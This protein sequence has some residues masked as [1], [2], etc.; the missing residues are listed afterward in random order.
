MNS[1]N[2]NHIPVLLHEA[3]EALAIKPD[4]YYVD[5]TLGACGHTREI[6]KRLS[7]KGR[8]LGFDCD[9]VA[10]DYAQKLNDKRLIVCHQKFSALGEELT[11]V[12]WDKVAGILVDLGVSS[13]QLDKADRGFSFLKPA[14]LDMRMDV[15][16]E[17]TAERWINSIDEL[18]LKEAIKYEGEERNASKI[19]KA[20]VKIRDNEHINTTTGL[21]EIIRKCVSGNENWR[22][23]ATRTFQAIRI[24]INAEHTQLSAILPQVAQ[25]LKPN[26][27]FVAIAFHSLEDRTIKNFINADALNLQK[28]IDALPKGL[29]VINQNLVFP[30]NY[31]RQ[32]GKATRA[33]AKE[34]SDNPRSHSAIM[35]VAEKIID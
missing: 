14:F 20:I 13:M 25:Y 16:Q 12:G 26:G 8:L 22:S 32:V 30:R 28:V 31:M 23:V 33:S 3:I 6:L 7:S 11:R 2:E 1:I 9:Q 21:C 27:R 35:R 17:L 10:I 4:E 29:P 5:L 18:T 34:Q 24:H 15:R 19:A